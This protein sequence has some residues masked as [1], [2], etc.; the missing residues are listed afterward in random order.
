M[1]SWAGKSATSA[2]SN[3]K[4]RYIYKPL[5]ISMCKFI[6]QLTIIL[7]TPLDTRDWRHHLEQLSKHKTEIE[8]SLPATK[9]QLDKLYDEISNTVE[10]IST[11]EK[12][13]NANLEP[14]LKQYRSKQVRFSFYRDPGC[15]PLL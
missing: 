1:A 9:S 13:L 5:K 6:L 3:N 11:R 8:E 4:N 10:K 12:H 7:H 2:K 14:Y 15:F